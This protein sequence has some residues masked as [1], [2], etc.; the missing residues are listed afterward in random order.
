VLFRSLL[1]EEWFG[2]MVDLNLNEA[3]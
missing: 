2:A 3:I 1:K